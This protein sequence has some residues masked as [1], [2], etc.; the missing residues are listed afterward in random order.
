MI[1]QRLLKVINQKK[2]LLG[3]GPMSKNCVDA[4]IQLSGE[5]KI[6]LMLIASRRQIDSEEFGGG[7]VNNW[8]TKTFSEY[9]KKN[10]KSKN[11]ILCRD[12]G[13]PWQNN[14]EISQNFNLRKAM[15]SAKRS[16]TAD[17]DN[18]LKV[19]HI[20][21][22]ISKSEKKVSP[23]NI[24]E[25]TFELYE[26]CYAYAKKKKKE[27]VFEVGTEEQSGSTNTFEEIEFF[28]SEITK[29]CKKNKLPN[30]F[31]IV[32]QSGTKVVELRN[33]GSFDSIVRVENQLPVEIQIIKL[34]EICKKYNVNFKE[35]NAD[36]LSQE[37]L[38]W[39]PFLGIQAVNVAPE[40]GTTETKAILKLMKQNRNYDLFDE[41]SKICINSKKWKKWLINNSNATELEKVIISG[42]YLFSSQE[43]KKILSE[44]DH[45]LK[46]KNIDMNKI[47]I[48]EIKKNILKYLKNFRLVK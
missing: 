30:I 42:H 9:V 24:L 38:R 41:F 3:I 48:K 34:I 4:S 47:I 13:G 46:K 44:L 23:K 19:I 32:L 20:D 29:F 40:F 27:I 18:N 8:N 35:H 1:S 43:G 10:D 37:S 17:I 31:F 12:H 39:H 11:I 15:E 22:S 14:L 25:R 6:P 36:Y 45:K 7:Y 26:Y 33:I 5:Y 21:A 28:L 16:Y 2:T